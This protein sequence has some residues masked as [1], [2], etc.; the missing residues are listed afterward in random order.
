[1][2]EATLLRIGVL[3]IE[4]CVPK[5]WTDEQVLEFVKADKMCV[6]KTGFEIVR[7]GD[8]SLKGEPERRQ[9]KIHKKNVHIMLHA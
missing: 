7:E 8:K 1:M 9:C 4:V 6:S 5:N 3:G 2:N